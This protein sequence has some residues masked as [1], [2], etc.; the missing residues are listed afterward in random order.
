MFLT[1]LEQGD[2]QWKLFKIKPHKAFIHKL[3]EAWFFQCPK[4][5]Q[6]KIQFKRFMGKG[7]WQPI[8]HDD[9]VVTSYFGGP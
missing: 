5:Q 9:M 4:Y 7:G 1:V 6:V 2:T 8:E 3:T